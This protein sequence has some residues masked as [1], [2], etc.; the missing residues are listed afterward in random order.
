MSAREFSLEA[1]SHGIAAE[2]LLVERGLVLSGLVVGTFSAG[3]YVRFDTEVL[4]VGEIAPGP[5]H[6][7]LDSR[8]VRVVAAG[9]APLSNLGTAEVAVQVNLAASTLWLPPAPTRAELD[10]LRIRCRETDVDALIGPDLA[11][12]WND[13]R[14][15]AVH[16]RSEEVLRM[17]TGRGNGLTPS[18]DDVLAGLMLVDAWEHRANDAAARRLQLVDHMR[19]TR[20]SQSFLRWAARGQSIEPVHRVVEVSRSTDADR[21]AD[22]TKELCSIGSSSGRALLAGLAVGLETGLAFAAL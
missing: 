6:V 3:C 22:A 19:T 14:S 9:V 4:A 16:G 8:S 18:G 7:V 21:F 2:E 17:L 11:N 12:V 15:A 10:A 1:A 13:V 5:L 20:L